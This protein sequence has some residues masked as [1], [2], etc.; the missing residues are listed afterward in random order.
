MSTTP[1]INGHI[2]AI[3]LAKQPVNIKTVTEDGLQTYTNPTLCKAKCDSDTNCVGWVHR[4]NTHGD[5]KYKNTCINF[6]NDT[7]KEQYNYGFTK[8]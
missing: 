5:V 3:K 2:R 7:S 4:D 8:N 1:Y 6:T